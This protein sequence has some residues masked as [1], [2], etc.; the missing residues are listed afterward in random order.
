MTVSPGNV[1]GNKNP[2]SLPTS[3]MQLN[4][5]HGSEEDSAKG[6]AGM[7]SDRE[8]QR[9]NISRR[10]EVL[11]TGRTSRNF[12]LRWAGDFRR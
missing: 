12:V 1:M 7:F 2:P 10:Q 4:G 9:R 8:G 5:L 3:R 11:T 6:N